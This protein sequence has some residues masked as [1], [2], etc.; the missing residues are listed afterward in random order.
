MKNVIITGASKGIGAETARVFAQNGFNVLINFNNS[1]EKA[2]NLR[3][4]LNKTYPDIT[5]DIFKCDVKNFNEC[6]RMAKYANSIFG[7]IDVLVANAGVAQ[8]K[9]FIDTT[10]NDFENIINT[11]LKGTFNIIKATLPNMISN[12][13]GKIVTVSSMWGLNGASCEGIY[14]AS[15]SGI[16]GLTKSLAKELGPSKINVNCVAP[17]FIATEMN[18]NVKPEDVKS[19]VEATPLQRVGTPRDV[20]DAIFFLA[21]D[22]ADFITGSVLSVDG[23]INL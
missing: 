17:G 15:K 8:I 6:E 19:M 14:S 7:N 22:K 11:N 13:S 2:I 5:A 20:A 4:E 21:S 9:P 1:E 12:K 3:N 16:I 23:A 18:S 10:E